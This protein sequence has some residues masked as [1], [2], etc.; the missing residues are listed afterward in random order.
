[1]KVFIFLL[2]GEDP[3]LVEK[4]QDP[5]VLD[6]TA[7]TY[8]DIQLTVRNYAP[9]ASIWVS[10]SGGAYNNGGQASHTFVDGFW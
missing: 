5:F 6:S 7:Q 2:S 1:M 8:K 10:E 9:W 4:M 3:N